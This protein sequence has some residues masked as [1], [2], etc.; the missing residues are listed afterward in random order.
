[1][2]AIVKSRIAIP[3]FNSF[4]RPCKT[5]WIKLDRTLGK[6]NT[7]LDTDCAIMDTVRTNRLFDHHRH[8]H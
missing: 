7:K 3:V 2:K 5:K 4:L 8:P 1:M 6:P